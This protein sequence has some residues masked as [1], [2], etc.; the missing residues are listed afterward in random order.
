MNL[1][2]LLGHIQMSSLV[3]RWHCSMV[4]AKLCMYNPLVWQ[5]YELNE[6]IEGYIFLCRSEIWY[7]FD[8]VKHNEARV[9]GLEWTLLDLYF[10]YFHHFNWFFFFQIEIEFGFPLLHL[11]TRHVK[12]HSLPFNYAEYDIH[13]SFLFRVRIC[14]CLWWHLIT[15]SSCAWYSIIE[16]DLFEPNVHLWLM[17]IYWEERWEKHFRKIR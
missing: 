12:C 4:D 17:F 9:S 2:C 8:S 14:R 1:A 10:R 5:L 13:V 6:Q 15:A 3:D 11:H 16:C 7:I